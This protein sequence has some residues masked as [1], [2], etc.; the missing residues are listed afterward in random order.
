M[1]A[2]RDDRGPAWL[3]LPTYEEASNIE[4]LVGE[5]RAKLPDS[6]QVLIVDDNSP[7]G[8]G[9]IAVRLAAEQKAVY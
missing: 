9:E 3:V 7:D 1:S 8:T 5:A 4:R 2:S 6:A